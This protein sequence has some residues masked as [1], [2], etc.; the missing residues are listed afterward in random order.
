MRFFNACAVI[1]SN[2]VIA[3][4][5]HVVDTLTVCSAAISMSCPKGRGTNQEV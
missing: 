3:G 2:T 5:K 4:R 1:T